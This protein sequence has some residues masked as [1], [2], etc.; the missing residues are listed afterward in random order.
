[1]SQSAYWNRAEEIQN[2]SCKLIKIEPEMEMVEL[3]QPYMQLPY[4][5]AYKPVTKIGAERVPWICGL[6]MRERRVHKNSKH[7]CDSVA[8]DSLCVARL[9][10]GLAWSGVKLQWMTYLVCSRSSSSSSLCVVPPPAAH[11]SKGTRRPSGL[12]M[13]HAALTLAANV[14]LCGMT[15]VLADPQSFVLK[16]QPKI[17]GLYASIYSTCV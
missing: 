10:D 1:M 16:I 5:L 15:R 2:C 11:A 13:V 9:N 3:T 4:I 17:V 12:L 7:A 8:P 6:I 14:W